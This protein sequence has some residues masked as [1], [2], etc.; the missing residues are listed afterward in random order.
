MSVIFGPGTRP[1]AELHYALAQS[2]CDVN[3]YVGLGAL[4]PAFA[5]TDIQTRTS[6]VNIAL[7]D[8]MILSYDANL[9]RM[10]FSERTGLS[11][12]A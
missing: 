12:D 3:W 11:R 6:V 2:A 5:L 7:N 8:A 9:S 1:P 10:E 4:I